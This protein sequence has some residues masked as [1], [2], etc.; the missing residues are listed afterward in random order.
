MDVCIGG[1][2]LKICVNLKLLYS[3][4]VECVRI[5]HSAVEI[6][7]INIFWSSL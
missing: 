2:R 6:G 1:E 5:E 4:H 3:M 7:S